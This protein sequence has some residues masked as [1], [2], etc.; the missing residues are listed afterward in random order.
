MVADFPGVPTHR[1]HSERNVR[2]RCSSETRGK[3]GAMAVLCFLLSALVACTD[4]SPPIALLRIVPDSARIAVG[5]TLQLV[6]I[7]QDE[8]GDTLVDRSVLWSS[9]DS[10]MAV[11]DS[12]GLV[13]GL[14]GG[15]V[16]IN[17]VAEAETA[18]ALLTVTVTFV[19]LTA[20]GNHNCARTED[21]SVYC[22]GLNFAG[23]LGDGSRTGSVAPRKIA[24]TVRFTSIDAGSN[25][26]CGI[27][28]NGFGYCWGS[29]SDGQLGNGT[30]SDW[31]TPQRVLA[32]RV[33]Q[34]I[35]AASMHSCGLT[36]DGVAQCWGLRDLLGIGTSGGTEPSPVPVSGGLTFQS[37]TARY[38][39]SCGITVAGDAYC[40]GNNRRGK[41][42]DN[43]AITRLTPTRVVGGLAFQHISAGRSHTCALTSVG[44]AYC[45][46]DNSASQLG[47]GTAD[48]AAHS[49]PE[50]VVGGHTFSLITAGDDYTCAISTSGQPYCWGLN[51]FGRLGFEISTSTAST[52]MLVSGN[53]VMGSVAT[54]KNHTC[55]LTVDSLVYCWGV[56]SN[57]QLGTGVPHFELFQSTMPIRVAFQN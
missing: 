3:N 46:G 8:D 43:T 20:G 31:T 26:T 28:V 9:Q 4:P 13:T 54:G 40:W 18:I 48:T 51:A 1:S 44:T 49:M 52:P 22:W 27:A 55:G 24:R 30:R 50:S 10:A 12:N 25:H 21:G 32:G 35:S 19:A 29:G 11:V 47:V 15:A 23:Q 33:F 57:G 38:S 2:W 7:A 16:E 42:G 53:L 6:A 39:H 17:A 34:S 36:T 56:N 41:L 14:A 45:W 37:L 5:S